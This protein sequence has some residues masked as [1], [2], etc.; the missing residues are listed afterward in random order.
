MIAAQSANTR[1]IIA[2]AVLEEMLILT[3]GADRWL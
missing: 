3:Y 2:N 1:S